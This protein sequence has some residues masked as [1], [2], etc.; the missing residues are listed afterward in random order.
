MQVF[1]GVGAFHKDALEFLR[2]LKGKK[3]GTTELYSKLTV[4][5]RKC[6]EYNNDFKFMGLISV[7]EERTEKGL[8]KLIGLTEKGEKVLAV[9]DSEGKKKKKK[10]K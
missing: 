4:S 5:T 3:L 9:I 7:E 6:H 2:K 10:K 8:R 1:F